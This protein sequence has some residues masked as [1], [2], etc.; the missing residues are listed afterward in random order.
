M[1][2]A[3]ALLESVPVVSANTAIADLGAERVWE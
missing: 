2:A 1:M 3:Q